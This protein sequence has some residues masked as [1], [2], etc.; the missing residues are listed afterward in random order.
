MKQLDIIYFIGVIFLISAVI[1]II[2]QKF[3]EYATFDSIE[4]DKHIT[5]IVIYIILLI[6]AI[7]LWKLFI[8]QLFGIEDLLNKTNHSYESILNG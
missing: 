4:V 2:I 6:F 7:I 3:Q 1:L 8:D 5:I